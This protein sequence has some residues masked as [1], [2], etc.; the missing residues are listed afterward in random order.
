VGIFLITRRAFLKTVGL[1]A[2]GTLALGGYAVGL[3]PRRLRVQR[4]SI[5]PPRWP[6]GMPLRIA[7]LAD[8]H[9]CEPW[10]SVARI[11]E[12]VDATNALGADIIVLLGDYCT[13]LHWAAGFVDSSDWAAA[14]SGLR[15]PLGVHAILGNHDWWEDHAAQRKGAGPVF[16]RVA[17]E[18][19]GIPVYENNVVKITKNGHAFWLAGLGDQIALVPR[20]QYGRK[21]WQGVDDLSGMLAQVHDEAPIILLAHEPDIFP[22]V[23]DRVALTL[24]G[25]THGGQVRLFGYSPVVPSRFGNRYA[26]GHVVEAGSHDNDASRHMVVSGGLGFSIAPVRFGVPPE[27]VLIDLGAASRDQHALSPV[28]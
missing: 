20:K 22:L 12:I 16:A 3:E 23:P 11:R 4:Y 28:L 25:H 5:A 14:L 26:Y 13:G 27:I 17:L 10:M 1:A 24:C 15:A 7:A 2:L 8:V 21:K 6:N 9:A 19:V 18:R